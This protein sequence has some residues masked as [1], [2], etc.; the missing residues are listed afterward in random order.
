MRLPLIAGAILLALSP[1]VAQEPPQCFSIA[2]V[3][4]ELTALKGELLGIVD[5]PGIGVDQIVIWIVQG[6]IRQAPALGGCM[7]GDPVTL[8][9]AKKTSLGV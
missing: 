6:V 3:Q 9:Q 1:A 5:I 8:V 2:D 7:V 4:D